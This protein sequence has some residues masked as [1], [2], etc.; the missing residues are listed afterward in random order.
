MKQIIN[1]DAKKDFRESVKEDD[2][3]MRILRKILRTS[4]RI[5]ERKL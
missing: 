3:N 4:R 2:M 5:L 1:E